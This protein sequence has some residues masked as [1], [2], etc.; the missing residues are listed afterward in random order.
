MQLRDKC[1]GNAGKSRAHHGPVTIQRSFGTSSTSPATMGRLRGGSSLSCL[2]QVLALEMDTGN[3]LWQRKVAD[4]MPDDTYSSS[5][6]DVRTA[7]WHLQKSCLHWFHGAAASSHGC[8]NYW[9]L[10]AVNSGLQ[11]QCL[12]MTQQ[13]GETTWDALRKPSA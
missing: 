7:C 6:R 1:R 3:T 11:W 4:S 12:R 2:A 10:S 13:H 5:G 8:L 9:T